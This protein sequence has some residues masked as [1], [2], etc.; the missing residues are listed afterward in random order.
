MAYT[1]GF[2]PPYFQPMQNQQPQAIQNSGLIPV[3]SESVARN[4]PVAFGQS[5]S[6]RD[7]NLP[8]LYTKTMGF[9]QLETP[10]FEK[11]RLVKEDAESPNLEQEDEKA[12]NNTYEVLKSQIAAIRH[13]VDGL[14]NEVYKP[15][16]TVTRKK[17]EVTENES[18]K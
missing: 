8:F 7:E 6:F 11:Y 1:N 13:D 17:K 4:Y 9:S 5:V 3:P 15:A 10:K 12:V 18:S 2:Y 14:M 16:I